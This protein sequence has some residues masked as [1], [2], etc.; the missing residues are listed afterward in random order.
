MTLGIR[1]NLRPHKLGNGTIV[2]DRVD[3]ALIVSENHRRNR[4]GV[5]TE[6]GPFYQWTDRRIV[7]PSSNI[8]AASKVTP[9]VLFNGKVAPSQSPTNPMF[10][11]FP[12]WDT[13]RDKATAYG[14]TGFKRARPGQPGV[15]ALVTGAELLREGLPAIPLK[16][17]SRLRNAK[18]VGKE[19][20]NYN[21]GW[22]PL[23]RD[24]QKMYQT[25]HNLDK[26]LQQ[27]QRDNGKG[28]RRRRELVNS[29]TLTSAEESTQNPF[30]YTVPQPWFAALAA[31]SS[32][33]CVRTTETVKQEHVWFMGKFKYHIPDVGSVEW[34]RRATKALFGLNPS[35]QV[36]WN[37]L[38]WSWLVD[39]FGNVG[40]VMSNLS[41]NA[42]ENC[43]AE[44][45]YVMR[46][47]TSYTRYTV[48]GQW[49]GNT[50]YGYPSGSYACSYEDQTTSKTRAPASPYGF[51][52]SWPDFTPYQLSILAALGVSRR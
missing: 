27:L 29:T 35:P 22:A 14:A 4:R 3:E 32:S 48:R 40:D 8:Y 25:Y 30:A 6:G 45:A 51:N 20:L 19:Y 49:V 44:Y 37:L 36:L 33:R 38:P 5:Y 9:G 46:Q 12:N 7:T 18:S 24:I 17:L 52:L 34:K 31:G 42:A 47:E 1:T 43:V 50:T 13:M 16:L 21:F 41:A 2:Y 39:W 10:R 26:L 23:V 11:S 15:D 28:I